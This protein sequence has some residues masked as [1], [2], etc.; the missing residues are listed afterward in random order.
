MH[1]AKESCIKTC[2]PDFENEAETRLFHLES[3]DLEGT[4]YVK[5]FTK[6]NKTKFNP[7]HRLQSDP[8]R[9]VAVFVKYIFPYDS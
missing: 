5:S 4:M 7:N 9:L 8:G 3:R 2:Y 6:Q 1:I